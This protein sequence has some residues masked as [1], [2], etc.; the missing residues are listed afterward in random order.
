MAVVWRNLTM[1][2]VALISR[3]CN[4][5]ESLYFDRNL[6]F[7]HCF[8]DPKI[9]KL[10][11]AKLATTKDGNCGSPGKLL[12]AWW[13]YQTY[14]YMYIYIIYIIYYMYIILYICNIIYIIL[15]IYILYQIYIYIYIYVY[16]YV[17]IYMVNG[18]PT[19]QGG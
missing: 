6:R 7:Y 19:L 16:V 2:F 5:C 8:W 3:G 15:Y 11:L 14:I 4:R 18:P 12:E 1:K 10:T 9:V 17:Y 13:I